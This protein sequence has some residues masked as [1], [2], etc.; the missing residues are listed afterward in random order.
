MHI[1]RVGI[2][3]RYKNTRS[4]APPPKCSTVSPP[5]PKSRVASSSTLGHDVC[6][7]THHT[8]FH[9]VEGEGT[10]VKC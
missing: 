1:L 4:V 9:L 5:F 3:A 10:D 7:T 2:T 8:R 6:D